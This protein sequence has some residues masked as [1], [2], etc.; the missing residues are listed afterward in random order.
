M[1][2]QLNMMVDVK[3]ITSVS[4]GLLN[5]SKTMATKAEKIHV[6]HDMVL[7]DVLFVS[8]FDLQLDFYIS[9]G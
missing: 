6:T 4:I 9:T 7:N 2:G 1:T 8:E 3:K 5:G